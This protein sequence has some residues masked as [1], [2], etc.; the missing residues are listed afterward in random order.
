MAARK[1]LLRSFNVLSAGTSVSTVVS[2][3]GKFA[4]LSAITVGIDPHVFEILFIVIFSTNGSTKI[5]AVIGE[6]GRIGMISDKMR[7]LRVNVS[8]L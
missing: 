3:V 5:D 7:R 2:A 1:V 6:I 8:F 4:E